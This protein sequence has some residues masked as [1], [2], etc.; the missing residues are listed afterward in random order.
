MNTVIEGRVMENKEILRQCLTH[1]SKASVGRD[2]LYKF[3]MPYSI[4][5]TIQSATG[6]DPTDEQK[7][8][9]PSLFKELNLWI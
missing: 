9:I 8:D 5:M 1:L 4:N 6:I 2:D 3:F 7:E